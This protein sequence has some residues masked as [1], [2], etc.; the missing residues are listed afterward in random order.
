MITQ[1]PV[2]GWLSTS[3]ND[4][5]VSHF[6][7]LLDT[8]IRVYSHELEQSPLRILSLEKVLQITPVTTKDAY[9]FQLE[10]NHCRSSWI[11]KC[12]T[13][14]DMKLWIRA[15]KDR[16][17]KYTTRITGDTTSLLTRRNKKLSPIITHSS[18][19]PLITSTS[20]SYAS[21]ISSSTSSL[22]SPLTTRGPP[23][24]DQCTF[25]TIKETEPHSGFLSKSHTVDDD[26]LSPTY[27]LYKKRFRL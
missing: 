4:Q 22:F 11:I 24:H 5:W 23:L 1:L 9:T 6:F 19:Q 14:S 20:S 2:A 26:E 7:V 8:E 17:M 13:E 27:L 15:I 18:Y 16:K 10:L 3:L 12:E 21:S 25:E